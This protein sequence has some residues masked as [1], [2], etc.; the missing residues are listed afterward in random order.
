ML[1]K[2]LHSSQV[3]ERQLMKNRQLEEVLVQSRPFHTRLSDNRGSF[4]QHLN[5]RYTSA[6]ARFGKAPPLNACM[7]DSERRALQ[8]P[9]YRP[10]V[11]LSKTAAI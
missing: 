8:P 9:S 7:S 2:S 11:S 10:S 4:Q 1:I 6:D 5:A 3:I